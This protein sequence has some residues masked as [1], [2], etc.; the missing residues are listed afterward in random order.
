MN[1]PVQ[2]AC[3]LEEKAK[4]IAV[5]CRHISVSETVGN[6]LEYVDPT[7]IRRMRAFGVPLGLCVRVKVRVSHLISNCK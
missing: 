6:W 3:K 2:I 7:M 4:F 1:E 5:H